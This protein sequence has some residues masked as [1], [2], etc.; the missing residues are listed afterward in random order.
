M[1]VNEID[2]WNTNKQINLYYK[3][4]HGIPLILSF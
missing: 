4:N 1:K 2:L 3:I